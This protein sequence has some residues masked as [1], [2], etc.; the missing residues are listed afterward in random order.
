MGDESLV[1]SSSAFIGRD[2]EMRT[3]A[4]AIAAPPAVMLVAGDPGVG[5]SRLV[6]E[7]LAANAGSPALI[8]SCPPFRQ[9]Y[10]LGSIVEAIR[11]AVE[12]ISGLP[13][14][15]LA[16]ALRGVFPEWAKGL[17]PAPDPLDDLMAARYRMFGAL[18][19]LIGCMSTQ[20]LVVEDAQWADD[21]TLEFLLF[22]TAR[23]SSRL[24]MILTYR[25]RD[26]S[27]DSLLPR[28]TSRPPA[29]HRFVHLPV[30]PLDVGE[31]AALVSSMLA[32]DRLSPG[33][34][35]FVHACTEGFPL[36]VEESV[37]LMADRADLVRRNGEWVRRSIDKI[38][39]PA[40]VRDA[41]LERAGRLGED[42]LAVLRAAAVVAEPADEAMLAAVTDLGT[43][44]VVASLAI[45]FSGGLLVE[46]GTHSVSFRHVL[47][48][49]AVYDAIPAALRRFMHLRAG[50]VLERASRPS[51]ARLAHHF[52]EA[53]EYE[54]WCRYAE[55]AAD[56]AL[57]S[58]DISGGL[59]SL[60][61]VI[62]SGKAPAADLCRL[63]GKLPLS[64]DM[65]EDECRKLIAAAQVA[66]SDGAA[67]PPELA[68]IRFLL[69]R[70]LISLGDV[71]AAM[72]ECAQAAPLLPQGS[73]EALLAMLLLGWARDARTPLSI[74]HTWLMRAAAATRAMPAV[75]RLRFEVDVAAAFLSLG[76]EEGWIQAAALPADARE[77]RDLMQI[78]RGAL[79]IAD[80]AIR[81]GRYAEAEQRLDH[82]RRLARQ[83]QFGR[84]DIELQLTTAELR[85]FRGDWAGLADVADALAVSDQLVSLA[86]A[87]AVLLRGLLW[88]AAGNRLRATR[89][90]QHQL[91]E[92]RR[93]GFALLYMEAASAL[94]RV[95][96]EEE[97]IAQAVEITEEPAAVLCR[98][99]LWFW[100]LDL[101]PARV[102]A[103][104]AAGRAD[105]AAE[106]GAGFAGGLAG[107]VAPLV[108]PA[109]QVVQAIAAAA[110]GE[111]AEAA[112]LYGQAA[113][114]WN[115]LPRPYDSLLAAEQRARHLLAAGQS[116]EGMELLASASQGLA[117]L[118]ATG[119]AA[120]VARRLRVNG[121]SA[122]RPWRGG[123]RGYGP[124]LSPR[125]LDVVRLVGT[126]Q[127]N[128]EIAAAL[129]R[130]PATVAAQLRSAMRK[131]GVSSRTALAV[132]AAQDGVDLDRPAELPSE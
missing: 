73:T 42:A 79:N 99:E 124:E 87:Q 88:L 128:K 50:R 34:A 130:A 121:G 76:D 59:A 27:P 48:A 94:A 64:A 41:V 126:G 96:L 90:F 116:D 67:T 127:T 54:A 104:V 8:A 114:A 110:A 25:P 117:D 125:E 16:G 66:L 38:R 58:W 47:A 22:L 5:K 2:R 100:G 74:H 56:L 63:A 97:R 49:Q 43:Q 78:T 30:G 80:A 81:W 60:H 119:D 86:R 98:K 91:A 72:T 103:L 82:G 115:D 123:R 6:S 19:E 18:A 84:L 83:N 12:D 57:A 118:G 21:T 33:F 35:E 95:Y 3:L 28:L 105:E 93:R 69:A 71:D 106:F 61:E 31:T 17:P 51:S 62:T 32:G 9:P 23:R 46:S 129:H 14:S 109:V 102:R 65:S 40:S 24:T 77:V 20:V 68:R 120:R 39:V 26:V 11:Q 70:T 37:R 29:G 1:V 108:T 15:G 92:A 53:G 36:A 75:N 132:R 131:L 113:S 122:P 44:R 111:H 10:T 101:A 7:F 4:E 55:Q 89:C 112:R 107:C 45:L 13:L 52:R 85:W